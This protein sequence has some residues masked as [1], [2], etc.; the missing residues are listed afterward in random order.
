MYIYLKNIT[1]VSRNLESTTL[2][3]RVF[4]EKG[5][6]F[7]SYIFSSGNILDLDL[8]LKNTKQTNEESVLNFRLKIFF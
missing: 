8:G 6:V 2:E 4:N 5:L 3:P 7:L 1:I